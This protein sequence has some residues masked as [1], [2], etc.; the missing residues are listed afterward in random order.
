MRLIL[1]E[2]PTVDEEMTGYEEMVYREF[3]LEDMMSNQ[4]GVSF[5]NEALP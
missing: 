4:A 3:E 5:M 1:Y 2:E